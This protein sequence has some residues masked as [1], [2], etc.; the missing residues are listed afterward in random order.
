MK[1]LLIG[2]LLA[3]MLLS[4]AACAKK[5]PPQ[6]T[7]DTA[8]TTANETTQTETEGNSI[9][10]VT[11]EN[12]SESTEEQ[13]DEHV[14]EVGSSKLEGEHAEI[15]EHA[16]SLAN[17]IQTYYTT[18]DR[19]SYTI[20]NQTSKLEYLLSGEK[21]QMVASLSNT[22]GN[23]YITDTMD[24][25]VTMANG[26][27]YYA[28]TSSEQT[29]VN[30]YRLGYYY[31]DVHLLEQDFI[32]ETKVVNSV[33]VDVNGFT[34]YKCTSQPVIKDG[35]ASAT[36]T[37]QED[38]HI[39]D[40][41]G[42]FNADE[43]NNLQFSFKSGCVGFITLYIQTGSNKGH[44]N[45]QSYAFDV[46]ADN[47]WHTYNVPLNKSTFSDY[48]G[49]VKRLRFDIGGAVGGEFAIKDVKMQMLEIDSVPLSLD[50]V[51]HSFPDKLHHEV[52]IVAYE[53]TKDIAE[54]GIETKLALDSISRLIFKTADGL[55]EFKIDGA[56]NA[57]IS[58]M[59][60]EA[61][62]ST[63]EYIAFDVKDAGIFGYILP[64]DNKSGGISLSFRDGMLAVIQT[65][66][67]TDGI[68]NA[69]VNST[70]NDFRM[71]H[72][73]YTDETH[74][75]E[76][77]LKEAYCERNPLGADNIVIDNSKMKRG[78]K[79]KGYDALRG[80]YTVTLP[81]AT[82]FNDPYYNNQNLYYNASFSITGDSYD[83]SLYFMTYTSSGLL[84]CATILDENDL[85]LPIALQVSKNFSEKEEPFYNCGDATYGEVFFP[86]AIGAGE[87]EYVT[88]LDIYQNWGIFPLKQLS[89]IGYYMPYYHLS[90]GTTETNC[91]SP[92]YNR[93]K[94][95]WTLPDHRPMSMPASSDLKNQYKAYG[96]QPQR[97]NAGYHFFLQYTDASGNYSASDYVGNEIHSYGPTYADVTMEYISDDGKIKA[98]LRHMEMPQVDENRGYYE[99]TYEVLDTLEIANFKND[100]SFYTMTGF[101][102]YHKIGYLNEKNESVVRDINKKD[103]AASFVLGDECPYFSM[104]YMPNVSEY[105]NL[106]FLILNSEI[107]I[108]GKSSDY[109]FV[110]RDVNYSLSLTLDINEITLKAGDKFIIN[111][112]IMPWGGGWIDDNDVQL[113]ATV[114]TNVQNV[115]LN[116]L[117]NPFKATPTEANDCETTD[118]VFLPRVKSTNGTSATFTVTGGHDINAESPDVINMTVRVDGIKDLGKLKIEELVG[119]DWI[120]YDTSSMSKPD[121]S[122]NSAS[123][124][125]YT[126]HYDGDGTYSYSF[127]AAFTDGN[128]RTFK[129]TVE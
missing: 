35:V 90:T 14:T 111:A 70:L 86:M 85:M 36:I 28:S 107:I 118:S 22:K 124:D 32:G 94:N 6:D 23:A 84:E 97:P 13:T 34:G 38:P 4:S 53:N 10:T 12:A 64:Y 67:P 3:S 25:F 126:V 18:P 98:T 115:R 44:T 78:A 113:H 26:S 45:S 82:T 55:T 39:I 20:E 52:H 42:V 89:S 27:K 62:W 128:S 93:G 83:R 122:G 127:V 16:A 92:W 112:I 121:N 61:D 120:L 125:G 2:I 72:R 11:D 76:A 80:V 24:V 74:D 46:I 63:A 60:K 88:V 110:L 65:A 57:D 54:I 21:D 116:T 105:A 49:E 99:I 41:S 56:S 48:G 117:L 96:N 79:F 77:F 33:D 91:I 123:F 75:F 69:P 87:Q 109:D 68:I 40:E 37:S 114:D 58:H 59:I 17:G 95:L 108:G 43:F 73:I 119:G 81:G 101:G 66:S 129:V 103:K 7:S 1:K 47:E 30:L 51:F 50:R 5:S 8:N 102:N 9:G 19:A 29:R 100:F 104:F 15:I 31:Y 106:S 71:G